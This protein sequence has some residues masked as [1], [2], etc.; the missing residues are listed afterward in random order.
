VT[1]YFRV[2][3]NPVH[4]TVWPDSRLYSYA[5]F[6]HARAY[7]LE[8]KAEL[9][10]LQKRGVSG[11]LN[12]ALGRVYFYNPVTGGFITEAGHLTEHERFLAP[13][14]QTHTLTAGTTWR[15]ARSGAFVGF[16]IEYGSGTPIGHGGAHEHAEGEATDHDGADVDE[17]DERVPS[18][19]M[20]G[21]SLGI[22]VLRDAGRRPRLTVR[23]DI[24][25]LTNTAYVIAQDSVFSPAQFSIPRLL[26][27]TTRVSWSLVVGSW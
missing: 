24:E 27:V 6:D 26:S 11:Y 15:H 23:L 7:G 17:V 1:G 19:V 2:T 25:N 16:T 8:A 22:D 20:A 4:T 14:D 13:M 12:Y 18:H 21:T 9:T 10:G 3:D 5:S